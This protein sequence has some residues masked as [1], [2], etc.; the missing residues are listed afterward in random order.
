MSINYKNQLVYQQPI[1]PT[2]EPLLVNLTL[3]AGFVNDVI[4]VFVISILS[5]PEAF[6]VNENELELVF[7]M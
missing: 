4:D 2:G 1:P 3:S 5:V 6:M 7:T